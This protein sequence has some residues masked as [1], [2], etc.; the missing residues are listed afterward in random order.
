MNLPTFANDPRWTCTTHQPEL[1]PDPPTDCTTD[2]CVAVGLILTQLGE[3]LEGRSKASGVI[4]YPQWQ[5]A[6]VGG[7]LC[8]TVRMYED[9]DVLLVECRFTVL[10]NGAVRDGVVLEESRYGTLRTEA[11]TGT[12]LG[13]AL[14][15]VIDGAALCTEPSD[16]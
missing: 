11:S 1:C 9:Y 6:T 13:L 4:I 10:R 16:I 12:M 8:V 7:V 15:R 2:Q 14:T 3:M 5:T